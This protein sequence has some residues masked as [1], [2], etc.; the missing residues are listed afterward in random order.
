[1]LDLTGYGRRL[2]FFYWSDLC[3]IYILKIL[4]WLLCE[5]IEKELTIQ[6]K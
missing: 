2:D 6:D 4:L 3:K 1:M 5:D